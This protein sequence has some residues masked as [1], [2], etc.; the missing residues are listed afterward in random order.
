[1][2]LRELRNGWDRECVLR[3]AVAERL[4]EEL[5]F[6]ID[7]GVGPTLPVYRSLCIGIPTSSGLDVVQ[8]V[9]IT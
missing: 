7:S 2:L 3:R 1:M 4:P 5:Q 6:P 9:P 8:D